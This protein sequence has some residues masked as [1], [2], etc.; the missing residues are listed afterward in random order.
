[1]QSLQPHKSKR[2]KAVQEF[3]QSKYPQHYRYPNLSLSRK[4][5]IKPWWPEETRNIDHG[6]SYNR[7][8]EDRLTQLNDFLQ[9]LFS[10]SFPPEHNLKLALLMY[11]R[12]GPRFALG[13]NKV[14]RGR[15]TETLKGLEMAKKNN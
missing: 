14:D 15:Q 2:S 1:M 11:D 4:I 6:S 10:I 7:D 13:P 5:P 8:Y 3:L 12:F 9:E